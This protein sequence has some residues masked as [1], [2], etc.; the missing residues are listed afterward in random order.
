MM[1]FRISLK[2]TCRTSKKLQ[3]VLDDSERLSV[4]QKLINLRMGRGTRASDQLPLRAMAPA[5][6]NEYEFRAAYYDEWLAKQPGDVAIPTLP[7]A[8]HKLLVE[9]RKEAYQQLCDIVYEKKGYNS[10]AVP[11]R[12]T[13]EKFDLLDAQA[14]ALLKEF[15]V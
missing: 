6:M 12:E 4:L 10:Q 1:Q 7:E 13:V 3:D 11:K 2:L 5:F 14:D 9:K 15:G 8:K